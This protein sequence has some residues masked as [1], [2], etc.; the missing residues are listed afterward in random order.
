MSRLAAALLIT[1]WHK[2]KPDV[3]HWLK[4]ALS[5]IVLEFYPY[6]VGSNF[7]LAKFGP[8]VELAHVHI[9]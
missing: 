2:E 3:L 9:Q 7:D 8:W 6:G 5:D 1:Y 4:R